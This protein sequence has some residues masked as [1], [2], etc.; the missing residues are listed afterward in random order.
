MREMEKLKKQRG[1][2]YRFE[3]IMSPSDV[4]IILE[5]NNNKFFPA[6]VVFSLLVGCVVSS[7]R[8]MPKNEIPPVIRGDHCFE[9]CL[10]IFH[11]F[12]HFVFQLFLNFRVSFVVFHG[13]VNHFSRLCPCYLCKR[14]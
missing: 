11:F 13:L 4:K 7:V 9:N 6:M 2:Q 3:M 12:I 5:N 14:P 1:D 10:L 8:A